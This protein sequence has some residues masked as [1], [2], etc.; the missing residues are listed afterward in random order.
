MRIR[1]SGIVLATLAF[2][3]VASAQTEGLSLTPGID[4]P[5]G[6]IAASSR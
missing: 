6:E 2:A 1:I 5:R 4:A 3:G